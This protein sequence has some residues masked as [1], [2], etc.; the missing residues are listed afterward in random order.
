[1][2]RI[3]SLQKLEALGVEGLGPDVLQDSTSSI[4]GCTCST[5]SVHECL[6]Q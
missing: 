1:M 6:P 3:L 2:S 4:F 5:N